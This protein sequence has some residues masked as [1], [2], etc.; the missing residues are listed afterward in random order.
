M[1][2]Q[3]IE[4]HS[5]ALRRSG[6]IAFLLIGW[7]ISAFCVCPVFAKEFKIQYGNLEI[8]PKIDYGVSYSNNI[9]ADKANKQSDLI[10]TLTPSFSLKKKI[11][12]HNS[13]SAE[14]SIGLVAY[15]DFGENNSQDH[16]MSLSSELT[17]PAANLSLDINDNYARTS[18]LFGTDNQYNVGKKTKRWNNSADFTLGYDLDDRYK[19]EL[20]YNN[21]MLRFDDDGDKWQNRFDHKYGLYI[22]Y[23]LTGKTSVFARYQQTL[24][25]YDEQNNGVSDGVSKWSDSTSQDHTINGYSVG[26][27]LK[28]IGR[29]YGELRFG[30]DTKKF[31]ND[32]NKDDI[33]YNDDSSWVAGATVNYK[34]VNKADISYTFQRSYKGSPDS[35]ASSYLDTSME[36][37]L[38]HSFAKRMS[39]GISIDWGHINYSG[40]KPELPD[41]SFNTYGATIDCDW[42]IA[43]WFTA[44]VGYEYEKKCASDG[45][46]EDE[47]HEINSLFFT[48]DF[49]LDF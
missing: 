31:N 5:S 29:L 39:A 6:I 4:V 49:D 10:H 11:G 16:N 45:A 28:P 40:E 17:F 22:F 12:Y 42:R 24:A 34:M 35:D 20:T 1:N 3:R 14:Y 19:L 46:Y 30:Y 37:S 23:K 25:E 38:S 2:I 36:L 27:R 9:Y 7:L 18:D 13:I 8:I 43:E 32:L 33:P 44:G 41:K 26:I 15:N 21:Y 48:F 47:E